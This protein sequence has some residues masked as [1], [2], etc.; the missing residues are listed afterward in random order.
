MNESW[1]A[2]ADKRPTPP[3]LKSDPSANARAARMG[4]A[5]LLQFMSISQVGTRGKWDGRCKQ[6]MR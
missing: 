4:P 1:N 6:D 3:I 5:G 2:P